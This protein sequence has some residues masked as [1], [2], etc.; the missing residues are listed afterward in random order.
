MTD[1]KMKSL[2]RVFLFAAA[3]LWGTSFVVMKNLL[4]N[5]SPLYILSFRFCGAAVLLLPACAGKLKRFDRHYLAGGAMM[6]VALL[7]GYIFQTY[8]LRG[9]TPGKNAFL[10]S[11][12]C[13]VAP[14]F[15]WALA[16]KRPDKFNVA[17]AA[18]CIAGIGLISLEG[19][20]SIGIGDAL[21]MSCGIFFALHIVV[22]AK[23]VSGRD[24]MMLAILQFATAGVLS[25]ISAFIF[26]EPP[27]NMAAGDIQGVIFLTVVCTA[28]CFVFQV[29]GQ[30]YTPPSQAAV[31]LTLES[32][33]GAVVSV[34]FFHEVLT[35]QLTV[36]F[37][38]A[39]IAVIISETK[40]EFLMRLKERK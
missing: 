23:S 4:S 36:G 10:T 34:I 5:I 12:Y 28:G 37:A 17:A 30:K 33:F 26:E 32:V 9:T 16:K 40:L 29:F 11:V 21:S 24:P 38:L 3:F 20:L 14:F 35:V 13:V 39:F 15:Q 22:S 2:G 19:E 18:V 7:L 31:I 6:G 8:G 25:L 1:T 27:V